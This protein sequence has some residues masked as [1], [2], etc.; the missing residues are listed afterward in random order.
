LFT[1]TPCNG[2]ALAPGTLLNSTVFPD[3]ASLLEHKQWLAEGGWKVGYDYCNYVDCVGDYVM[4]E[5][6][7]HRP[8]E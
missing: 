7:M 4:I 3:V 8:G 2:W 6:I 1:H 5:E